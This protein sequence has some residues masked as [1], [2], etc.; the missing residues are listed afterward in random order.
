LADCAE[1]GALFLREYADAPLTKQFAA[2]AAQ[3]EHEIARRA[4][5]PVAADEPV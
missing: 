3:F 4:A 5:Q 1:R 2:M